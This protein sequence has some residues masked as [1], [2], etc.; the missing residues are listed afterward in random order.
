[1]NISDITEEKL[2]KLLQCL[3]EEFSRAHASNTHKLPEKIFYLTDR[4]GCCKKAGLNYQYTTSTNEGDLVTMNDSH[5][6]KAIKE[7]AHRGYVSFTGNNLTFVLTEKGYEAG[8]QNAAPKSGRWAAI[9]S[10]ANEH[11][12]MATVIALFVFIAALVI[13]FLSMPN[14]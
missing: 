5:Y 1:M 6:V 12:G 13:A 14:A 9:K 2:A 4:M 3:A 11:Q 8:T 10:W 7:L